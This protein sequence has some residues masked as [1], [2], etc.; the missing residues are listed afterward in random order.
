M[1]EPEVQEPLEP[2]ER[3]SEDQSPALGG[4]LLQY[5]RLLRQYYWVLLLTSIVGLGVAYFWTERQPKM[6]RAQSKIVFHKRQGDVLGRNIE[7][8]KM[9]DPGGHWAFERFW[10]TQEQIF[11][12]RWFLERVV[13]SKGLLNVPG[14]LDPP[15]SGEKRTQAERIDAAIGRLQSAT[16][17]H[18]KR[19]SR[20]GIIS[21]RTEDPKLAK[22]MANG[23]AKSY[24]EYTE[25][26]QS[27]GLKEITN[28]FDSYVKSKRKDL[29][30]AQE[31]LQNFRQKNNILSFSY[32]DRQNL[33]AKNI[34]S[35]NSSLLDT[36]KKLAAKTALLKQVKSLQKSGN[37]KAIASLTKDESLAD[38]F[39]REATLEEEL[40]KLETKYLTEHPKVRAVR[41]Q[42]KTVRNNIDSEIQGIKSGL[43]NRVEVL[44]DNKRQL[45]GKLASHKEKAFQLD[46]LGVEYS[47]LKGRAKNLKELYNTV[48]QRSSELDINSLYNPDNIRVLERAQAPNAPV[49]PSLP[50][51]LAVGLFLGLGL[52]AGITIVLDTMDTTIKSKEE[53]S[54]ISG[55]PV[56]TMLPELTPTSLEG[57]KP[58]GESAA[59]TITHTAPKSTFAEGIKT[60]RTNLTFMSPDDPPRSILVTSPGPGEG[61]TLICVNSGIAAAQSGE[62]TV[63]VDTDLRKPRL[64]KT[65]GLDKGVGVTEIIGERVPLDE[66]VQSTPVENLDLVSSG[67]IPPNPSELFHSNR[68][69]EFVSTLH[70]KYDKVFYDSPPIG[71]VS[72]PLVL[73]QLVDGVIL[74]VEFEQTRTESLAQSIEQMSGVGAPLL[75][76]VVNEV[77]ARRGGYYGYN[78]SYYRYADY[79]YG[80]DEDAAADRGQK[81]AS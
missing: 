26:Q 51:N 6:Y 13:E 52:G 32:K 57:V 49:S 81:L 23:M 45:E 72:D 17:V 16:N 62:S 1:P 78:Y 29:E 46:E 59:D 79:H 71:A 25:E 58:I 30:N 7:E 21:A 37:S 55:R 75:G 39:N 66:G 19:E 50:L 67:E 76:T 31:K 33:T 12:S 28:W 9:V 40:A 14:F 77:S 10:N 73:S 61:K 53:V 5:W 42:L 69:E 47:R 2:E 80:G 38:M 34:E 68:F 24:V 20:V 63:L 3:P 22:K 4:L 36:R 11:K 65:L 35:I 48:L 8:V 74:V 15:S 64:H 43:E 18:L 44:R 41:T 56:L 27:G 54:D 70:D 60:L